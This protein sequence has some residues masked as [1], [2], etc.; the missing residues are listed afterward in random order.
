MARF[1]TWLRPTCFQ[2]NPASDPVIG[3]GRGNPGLY[4][5]LNG[6]DRPGDLPEIGA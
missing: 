2:G 6:P 5:L 3:T 4:V 1:A